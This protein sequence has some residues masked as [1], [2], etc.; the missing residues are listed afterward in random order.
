MGAQVLKAVGYWWSHPQ[1]RFP[2]NDRFP[3]PTRLVTPDWRSEERPSI[4][5]YLRSGWIYAAWRGLSHCRF[6]CR[7][8][9]TGSRCL[10]DGEWVWP[11]GLVH[12]LEAHQ[13]RLPDEFIESM[14]RRDWQL[15][16]AD[17]RA[18]YDGGAVVDH[19]FWIAW[20]QAATQA[21]S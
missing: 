8:R 18:T 19:S 17:P 13:V 3:D 7:E 1:L 10:T 5:R 15:P 2:E 21:T 12:Y 20:G 16:E 4:D 11:E 6:K 14:R 9:Y